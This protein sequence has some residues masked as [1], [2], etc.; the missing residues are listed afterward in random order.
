MYH[1]AAS[2]FGKTKALPYFSVAFGIFRLNGRIVGDDCI[3]CDDIYAVDDMISAVIAV[4]RYSAHS[5]RY[6]VSD[7]GVFIDDGFFDSAVFSDTDAWNIG[8]LVSFFIA[9]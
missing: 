7:T 8:L 2:G 5:Y 1:C 6:I 9:V 4:R 3:F